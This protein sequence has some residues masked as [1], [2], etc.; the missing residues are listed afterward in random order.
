MEEGGGKNRESLRGCEKREE[1]EGV[2]K[3]KELSIQIGRGIEGKAK[4]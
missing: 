4:Q 2:E 1:R 3:G